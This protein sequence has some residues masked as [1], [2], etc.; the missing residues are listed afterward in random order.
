M[1]DLKKQNGPIAALRARRGRFASLAPRIR[2]KL[3]AGV[4]VLLAG[5]ATLID[6]P[7]LTWVRN[8]PEW[9]RIGAEFLT[10]FGK[11]GWILVVCGLL[12]GIALL[13][14]RSSRFAAWKARLAYLKTAVAYVFLSVAL[15]GIL[16]NLAKRAVGR[17]RPELFDEYGAYHFKSFAFDHRFESFPSGHA[18]TDGAIMMAMA[19][20]FP[21]WRWPLLI[22]GFAIALTRVFV[23]AHYLSDVITGYS[24]GMWYAYM[25]AIVFAAY[26][27]SWKQ[28]HRA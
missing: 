10:D 3:W 1:S 4:T 14:A 5:L 26:G 23:E 13:A 9:L 18:T 22:I 21:A 20:L 7:V 11:S 28:Q 15:S 27:F 17:A 24:F 19:I 12:F 2:W 8:E 16:A 6:V 25:S